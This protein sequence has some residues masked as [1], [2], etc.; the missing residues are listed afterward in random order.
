MAHVDTETTDQIISNIS[1][2]VADGKP[3][4]CNTRRDH[5]Q[6]R[7]RVGDRGAA[8]RSSPGTPTTSR[9][10][11]RPPGT[12]DVQNP[13][14]R[15]TPARPRGRR[16][17]DDLR[18]VRHPRRLGQ[19]RLELHE[20][21]QS[22]VEGTWVSAANIW[23]R[24]PIGH[25]GPSA[26]HAPDHRRGGTARRRRT[27]ARSSSSPAR[28]G[29]CVEITEDPVHRRGGVIL[30]ADSS[31]TEHLADEGRVCL[32]ISITHSATSSRPRA[33]IST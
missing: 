25:D 19:M 4:V 18:V 1:Q 5:H 28:A 16:L 14:G 8:S 32:S 26:L 30:R 15:N 2:A 33:P 17:P 21:G 13:H 6:P 11:A 12:I 7:A 9:A 10:R 31:V 22:Q 20:T 27:R 3:V 23:E 24:E 29:A